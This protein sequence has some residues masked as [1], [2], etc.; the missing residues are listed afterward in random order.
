MI[1]LDLS[2][3]RPSKEDIP[4]ST[5]VSG[6]ADPSL[7]LK[8]PEIELIASAEPGMAEEARSRRMASDPASSALCRDRQK[9][10]QTHRSVILDKL[11]PE[12]CPHAS[13]DR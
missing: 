4:D 8:P 13:I 10:R 9:S 6:H 7:P 5:R 11:T 2:T 1:L 12:R 3:A